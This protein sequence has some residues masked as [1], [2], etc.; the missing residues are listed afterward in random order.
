MT[1][2][3]KKITENDRKKVVIKVF[4]ILKLKK[5][6]K[7]WDTLHSYG[8]T[9]LMIKE[10]QGKGARNAI[11]GTYRI[12]LYRCQAKNMDEERTKLVCFP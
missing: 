7:V 10:S 12:V 2:K 1:E 11:I 6:L 8:I 9:E 4:W 3:H 5:T